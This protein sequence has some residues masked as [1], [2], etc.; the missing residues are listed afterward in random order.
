MNESLSKLESLPLNGTTCLSKMKSIGKQDI[1]FITLVDST[2]KNVSVRKRVVYEENGV[3]YARFSTGKSMRPL[4]E[5][6]FGELSTVIKYRR[7]N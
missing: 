4:G 6:N 1:T 2:V 7:V 5:N 3:K